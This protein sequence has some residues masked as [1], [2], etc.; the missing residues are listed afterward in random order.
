M[1]PKI[2][3][4]AVPND[5]AKAT[6]AT[7]ANTKALEASVGSTAGDV[8][9]LIEAEGVSAGV[10]DTDAEILAVTDAEGVSVPDMVDVSD[11]DRVLVIDAELLGDDVTED[12]GVRE[13]VPDIVAVSV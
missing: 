1:N 2:R 9:A 10:R 13:E 7:V 3:M 6:C 12:D 11:T 5:A 8:E 4:H